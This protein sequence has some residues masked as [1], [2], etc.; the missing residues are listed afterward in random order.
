MIV[1]ADRLLRALFILCAVALLP[2][3]APADEVKL[4]AGGWLKNCKVTKLHDGRYEIRTSPKARM[5][6]AS[7]Q[8]DLKTLVRSKTTWKDTGTDDKPPRP[9]PI[10][11]Q[12]PDSGRARIKTFTAALK[13]QTAL[14]LSL[15]KDRLVVEDGQVFEIV[16]CRYCRGRGKVGKTVRG[17]IRCLVCRGR[18]SLLDT[19]GRLA[20]CR[21]CDG[22]G[23]LVA[24]RTEL[25]TCR[26]CEGISD[27]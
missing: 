7:H 21:R 19:R 25:V 3:R 27:E 4:T 9:D 5:R 1:Y 17:R 6:V 14:A 13:K 10:P 18:G 20:R 16:A 23:T 22:R 2:L 24:S 11:H 12:K 26:F 15:R 8:L